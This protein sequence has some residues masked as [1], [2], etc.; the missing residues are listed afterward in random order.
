MITYLSKNYPKDLSQHHL[1]KQISHPM[2]TLKLYHSMNDLTFITTTT[3]SAT[4]AI[5]QAPL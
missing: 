4:T 3:R 1:H 5:S 2:E